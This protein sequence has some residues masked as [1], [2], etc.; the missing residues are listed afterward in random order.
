MI[1][2]N[3]PEL[4]TDMSLHMGRKPGRKHEQILVKFNNPKDKQKVPKAL[5]EDETNQQKFHTQE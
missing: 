5:P 1:E 4:K 2:K 3:L